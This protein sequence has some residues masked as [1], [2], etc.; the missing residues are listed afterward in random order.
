MKRKLNKKLFI[1]LLAGTIVLGGAVHGVHILQAKQTAKGLLRMADEAEGK[2]P[3]DLV[4]AA[5]YLYRYLQFVPKDH[6]TLARYGLILDKQADKK[7]KLRER[8]FMVLD[9]A[10][11]LDPERSDVRL[12]V[13]RLA[14]NLRRFADAKVHLA[15]LLEA[16]PKDGELHR[17]LGMCEAGAGKYKEAVVSLERAIQYPPTKIESYV[18]LATIL[19]HHCQDGKT[20]DGKTAGDVMDLMV[21]QKKS[22]QALLARAAYLHERSKAQVIIADQVDFLKRA[23]DDIAAA[24]ALAPDDATV[25]LETAGWWIAQSK[26]DGGRHNARLFIV[27]RADLERGLSLHPREPRLYLS[28][29]R[30][31]MTAGRME[32]AVGCLRQGLKEVA[33]EDRS[34]LLF[35][36]AGLLIDQGSLSEARDIMADIRRAVPVSSARLDYLDACMLMKKG[37]LVKATHA[38]ETVRPLLSNWPALSQR[39]DFL[40]GDCNEQLGDA[41]Q[42]YMAFRRALSVDPLSIPAAHGMGKALIALGKRDDA[43][44]V[45]RQLVSRAPG[46]KLMIAR[47]LVQQNLG[48][49]KDLQD[50]N[51]VDALLTEL[52]AANPNSSAILTEIHLLE[53][54]AMAAR[55]N[56]AGAQKLL[57]KARADEDKVELW[58]AQ[59]NLAGRDPKG[60]SQAALTILKEAEGKFGDRAELRL[61]F[62]WAW[63]RQGGEEAAQALTRLTENLERFDQAVQ[64]RLLREFATIYTFLA[65]PVRAEQFLRR[66][67]KLEPYNLTVKLSLFDL[68][69]E[70]EN[71]AAMGKLIEDMREIEGVKGTLW[72]YAEANRLIGLARKGD[73]RQLDEANQVLLKLA[74]ERPSWHLL[75]ASQGYIQELLSKW[76]AAGKLYH[77]AW[78]LGDRRLAV[79]RRAAIS[80]YERREYDALREVLDT[81]A[82]LPVDLQQIA[83]ALSLRSEDYPQALALAKKAVDDNPNDYRTYLGLAQVYMESGKKGEAEPVL[84][85]AVTLASDVPE[86]WVVLVNYLVLTGQKKEAE[87][88]IRNA[89]QKL[90]AKQAPLALAQCY[91]TVG[92]LEQAKAWHQKAI[93]AQAENVPALQSMVNFNLRHGHVEDAEKYLRQIIALKHKNPVEA[94]AAQEQLGLLLVSSGKNYQESR[95]TLEELGLLPASGQTISGEETIEQLRAKATALAVLGRR[96]DRLAAM[97]ILEKMRD[98]QPLTSNDQF[99]LAQMYESVGEWPKAKIE[100]SALVGK[101]GKNLMYLAWFARRLLLHGEADAVPPLLAKLEKF[102]GNAGAT[103]EITAR[104]LHAQGKGKKVPE[105]LQQYAQKN[106]EQTPAIALLLVELKQPE[107][108]EDML[109]K[110]VDKSKVPE[111]S[112]ILAQLLG[113]QQGR[114]DEALDLCE[115]AVPTCRPEMVAGVCVSI[116]Y[117]AKPGKEQCQRVEKLL[118]AAIQ[119]ERKAIL[120]DHLGA[121][122]NL[123]GNFAEAEAAYRGALQLDATDKT[124][125]NN[126][127]WLLAFQPQKNAEALDLVERAIKIS[128]PLPGLLDTRGKIHLA[129]GRV[130]KAVEDLKNAVEEQPSASRYF[131]LVEAYQLANRPDD[132]R[133]AWAAAK[134]DFGLTENSVHPLERAA[135]QKL[136]GELE[137]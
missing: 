69:L 96:P 51:Q 28:L 77:Q 132:A 18:F 33:A 86:P 78:K 41:E 106:E 124:A 103:V 2:D 67:E 107:A 43:I 129:A 4:K 89:E 112:L 94:K 61:A 82:V 10:V 17:L 32:H 52:K 134:R 62:A 98:R 117:G 8:A 60:G 88:E 130:A 48:V 54:E 136:R 135:Y 108:A 102:Y 26:A 36:L 80:L 58:I 113:R 22:F 42:Q 100:A 23:G 46:F 3:P 91:E 85:K 114:L 11:R 81:L 16:A 93:A 5:D 122:H 47:L 50:W 133:I 72:R 21:D 87:I 126:L 109:R 57:A 6:K 123:Q 121:L 29:C 111:S 101:E 64:R 128:G 118:T 49:R 97:R 9:Q 90:P 31:E 84:R 38:L 116:L 119:K 40:L 95:K 13:V 127:A 131:H 30:L 34:E 14:M 56:L 68:A 70:S 71:A 37:E 92:N 24:R 12:V 83:V 39:A 120:L 59:A 15:V 73:K 44:Q 35:T 55:G 75:P 74:A 63:A 25:L 20:A 76:D 125:L 65:D 110:Y 99:L 27:A 104:L 19:W 105:L 53:A 66:L 1:W 137:R 115:K 79:V 45:Y 7:P